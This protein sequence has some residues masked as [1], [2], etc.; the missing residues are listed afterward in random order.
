MERMVPLVPPAIMERTAL[1]VPL[2]HLEMME[3]MEQQ[4]LAV[5][6][7]RQGMMARTV[8]LELQAQWVLQ[9]ITEQ[10]E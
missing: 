1:Q 3:R 10:T 4:G 9:E 7:A 8:Q 2:A 6:Q 5:Q